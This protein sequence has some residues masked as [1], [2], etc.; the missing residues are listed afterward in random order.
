[1]PQMLSSKAILRQ[2]QKDAIKV[3]TWGRALAQHTVSAYIKCQAVEHTIR[4]FIKCQDVK[5]TKIKVLGLNVVVN[6][7]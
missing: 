2:I 4:A 1:M 7:G 5:H 3:C 6:V